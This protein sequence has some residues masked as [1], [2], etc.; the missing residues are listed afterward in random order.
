MLFELQNKL[1]LQNAEVI[2]YEAFFSK[3]ESGEIFKKL[4]SEIAWKQDKIKMYGKVLDLPRLT[5]WYGEEGKSYRYSGIDMQIHAWN[6]VLLSIKNRIEKVA[7]VNFNG[8]L[9]NFYRNGN[10]SMSWHSDDEKELGKNPVIASVSFGETRKFRLRHKT[11]KNLKTEVL[12]TNGSLLL[13]QGETQHFWQH[14]IP[15]TKRQI[16]ERINLTFRYIL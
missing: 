5:A 12:L 8:A 10:D 11:N 13:M 16:G 6:E 2:L 9:L 15:K 1:I 14:E 7:N 4:V 3:E